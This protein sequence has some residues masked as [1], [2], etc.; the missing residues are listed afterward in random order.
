LPDISGAL[1]AVVLAAG[2]VAGGVGSMLGLG[3]GVFL[4]PF[5]NVALSFP[6]KVA[7]GVSLM[8]VV[9]TSSVVAR[10]AGR[11]G[12][13]NLRLGMVLQIAAAAGGY[14]G[15]AYAR[16]IP[17][18]VLQVM[19]A[20]VT[21]AIA[22]M[23]LSRLERR[24]VILDTT[25]DP[26]MFGGRFYEEESGQ[27]VVYRARRLPA[28]FAVSLVSGSISGLLGLGGAIL[29]VP[30]LNAWCGIPLRVAA[31]TSAVMIGITAAASA[32]LYYARGDIEPP[33]AAAA[34]LGTFIG[35]RAGLWFGAR[36]PVKWLK[37]L[38]AA[39]LLWV[40]GMYLFKAL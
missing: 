11:S 22:A 24:N 4:V 27:E 36:A 10:G 25:T 16:R 38:M 3:G 23:M 17:D 9:A 26:G 33:L 15:G 32:P 39:I 8:T 12:M 40:S 21:A 7:S 13:V 31:A 30:A 14:F 2:A 35:S 19:F 18:H 20:V 5:L 34:V 29:Q 1:I 6:L 28:A 37:L